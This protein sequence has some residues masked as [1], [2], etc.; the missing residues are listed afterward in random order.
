MP[1]EIS[2]E[3]WREMAR[4]EEDAGCD[5]EAGLDWGQLAGAYLA[6]MESGEQGPRTKAQKIVRG[7]ER[8]ISILCKR[9]RIPILKETAPW[10]ARRKNRI[11][12]TRC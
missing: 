7:D 10:Y 5:V 2:P 6:A 4:I 9:S 12:S 1:F 8:L 11:T 3:E